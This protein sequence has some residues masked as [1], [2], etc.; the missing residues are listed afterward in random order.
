[1]NIH[2]R[3]FDA[4]TRDLMDSGLLGPVRLMPMKRIHP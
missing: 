3:P 4:S 1:V 2:Y